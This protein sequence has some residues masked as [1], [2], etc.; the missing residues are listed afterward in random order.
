VAEYRRITRQCAAD[1]WSRCRT[2][3]DVLKRYGGTNNIKQFLSQDPRTWYAGE[4]LRERRRGLKRG[5]KAPGTRVIGQVKVTGYRNWV[6]EDDGSVYDVKG[7]FAGFGIHWMIAHGNRRRGDGRSDL[8][9]THKALLHDPS[10]TWR[11]GEEDYED[12]LAAH[13][14]GFTERSVAAIRK[15]VERAEREHN[16]AID[17]P[18]GDVAG[19]VV[20]EHDED[21][22]DGVVI[23]EINE[24]WVLLAK[25]R[26]GGRPLTYSD[27]EAFAAVAYPDGTYPDVVQ[28]KYDIRDGLL[29]ADPTTHYVFYAELPGA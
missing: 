13:D 3:E 23:D 10:D 26:H 22:V 17:I 16:T 20:H 12:L 11:P 25:T 21:V 14:A 1:D 27:A 6:W 2:H 7:A 29:V 19:K 18:S 24:R 15:A 28:H 8:Q 4:N 9:E 5:Q